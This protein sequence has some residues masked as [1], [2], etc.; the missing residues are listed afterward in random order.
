MEIELI[1]ILEEVVNYYK[2]KLPKNSKIKLNFNVSNNK[3]IYIMG[4]DVLL[5]WAFENLVKNSI[6]SF[7]D[8]SGQIDLFLLNKNDSIVIDFIDNGKGISRKNK[9][10]I[11]RPGFSTKLRGWGL[12]LNLTKR[13]IEGIHK[14]SILL[15]KSNSQ[16]TI[17]RVK[18][19]SI[20]S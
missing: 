1:I 7:T 17:F 9:R 16:Q 3:N 18:L 6:D 15:V 14:G 10:N 12:G 20:I 2:S 8:N 11:F 4:D 13:I 5:Y 19:K